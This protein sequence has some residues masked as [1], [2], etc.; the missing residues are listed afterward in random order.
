MGLREQKKQETHQNVLKAAVRLFSRQG[1]AATSMDQI[2]AEV[3]VSRSTLFN[4][5]SSKD[6]IVTALAEPFESLYPQRIREICKEPATT[7]QRIERALA[8]A[9]DYFIKYRDLNQ[10]IYLELKR[11]R[12]NE[13]DANKAAYREYHDAFIE[14]LENG[15]EQGDVRQDIEV[16]R[17]AELLTS[18]V[19]SGVYQI[20]S[21]GDG[22]ITEIFSS[23]AKLFID[24]IT[25][26]QGDNASNDKRRKS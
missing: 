24:A 25:V 13:H 9:A 1:F 20:F 12:A 5:F 16:E 6:A 2:A 3:N 15:L 8:V 18:P 11:V 22:D 4:Y 17:M 21:R 14:L 10:A 7:A 23:Y 19:S 26:A